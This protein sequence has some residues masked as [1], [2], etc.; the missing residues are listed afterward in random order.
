M[1]PMYILNR[2]KNKGMSAM[3]FPGWG[4]TVEMP[5][6]FY[7][8]LLLAELGCDVLQVAYTYNRN[9]E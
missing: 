3:L 2:K 9:P 1:Y 5:A 6:M 4:Y 7:T 8:S